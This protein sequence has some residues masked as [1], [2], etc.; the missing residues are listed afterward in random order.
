VHLRCTIT[1]NRANARY[2]STSTTFTS[3]VLSPPSARPFNT[4][5][6]TYPPMP[7][8]KK[9][10]T[11]SSSRNPY[12]NPHHP[13]VI[14]AT[15]PT[16]GTKPLASQPA[17][18][19]APPQSASPRGSFDYLAEA[20]EALGRDP[21][22]GRPL[23][24]QSASGAAEPSTRRAVPAPVAEG[25]HAAGGTASGTRGPGVGVVVA[26]GRSVDAS[27]AFGQRNEGVTR[28]HGTKYDLFVQQ[29]KERE[30]GGWRDPVEGYF[31][32]ERRVGEF[33]APGRGW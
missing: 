11:S 17:P 15:T 2:T 33:Y 30:K 10:F 19:P 21:V 28:T 8:L 1:T 3:C 29:M 24:S 20:R 6:S 4:S 25:S 27:S 16:A 5:T 12:T 7:S 22:T 23:P 26:Q 13:T 18:Q 31:A 14:A 9:L 32:P